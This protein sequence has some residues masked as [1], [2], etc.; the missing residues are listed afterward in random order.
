[1]G[2]KTRIEED[3]E[4]GEEEDEVEE[5]AYLVRGR[6]R[7][8]PQWPMARHR[9]LE[10]VCNSACR[11]ITM[12]GGGVASASAGAPEV[13]D[14]SGGQLISRW[15]A[16]KGEF[17]K[18][19]GGTWRGRWGEWKDRRPRNYRDR[20]RSA[21]P[22]ALPHPPDYLESPSSRLGPRASRDRSP[23][24]N[25]PSLLPKSARARAPPACG[26]LRG[27]NYSLSP[28]LQPLPPPGRPRARAT[29]RPLRPG[30]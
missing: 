15:P 14:T 27:L 18:R 10:C 29:P 20:S 26:R 22:R 19:R 12:A 1:V 13:V 2:V 6:F 16:S 8:R 23:P 30:L 21:R 28:P 25:I 7:R 3:E 9:S 17:V 11:G 4:E 5:A 24:L